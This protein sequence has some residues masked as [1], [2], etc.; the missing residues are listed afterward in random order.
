M[1]YDNGDHDDDNATAT[2]YDDVDNADDADDANSDRAGG[3]S[4]WATHTAMV[5]TT[6]VI[7]AMV[8]I[9]RKWN[10]M[11]MVLV[12]LTAFYDGHDADD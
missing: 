7:F 5:M 2:S 8:T 9:I 6:M 1:K 3:G 12:N 11:M 4:V 10:I